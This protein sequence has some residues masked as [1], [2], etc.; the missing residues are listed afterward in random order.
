MKRGGMGTDFRNRLRDAGALS[1]GVW[2]TSNGTDRAE[3][4]YLDEAHDYAEL[5]YA[6]GFAFR[7]KASNWTRVREEDR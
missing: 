1:Q 2:A 4:T 7:S 3:V 6:D 5:R